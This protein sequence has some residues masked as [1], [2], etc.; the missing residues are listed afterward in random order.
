LA[1]RE[2]VAFI[3]YVRSDDDHDDGRISQLRKLLEGEVKMQ[4]G[5][6][7]HIFQDRNDINWGQQW[8]DRIEDTILE[9]TFLIPI[10]TPSYF[11][12]PM[13]KME[14]EAF[15]IREKTLGEN[16]LILPIYYV[17]CVEMLDGFDP[18]DVMAST[19]RTRNWS[20][21]RSFRFEPLTSPMLRSQVAEL[22]AAI[23]TIMNDLISI[24]SASRKES[25]GPQD[26]PEEKVI[27]S[28]KLYIPEIPVVRK[29]D[30]RSSRL[31]MI[32]KNRTMHIPLIS[33][34]P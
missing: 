12:S 17:D 34:K 14:F 25:P 31:G 3:S 20:D 24:F 10:V 33:T 2:P 8:K 27:T 6:T 16:R 28:Y 29:Q 23:K 26:S 5:K 32:S 7:F 21:W 1:K 4:T 9:I 22:A 19:L 30:F 18:S 13:C 11:Q 15:L